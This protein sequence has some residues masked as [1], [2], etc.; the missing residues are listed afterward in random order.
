MLFFAPSSLAAASAP[1]RAA[2]NTGLVELFAM[3][4]IYHALLKKISRDPERVL[5]ERVS[6]SILDKLRIASRA[7]RVR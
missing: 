3:T 5:R 1:V 2:R 7:T 6:L 4:A